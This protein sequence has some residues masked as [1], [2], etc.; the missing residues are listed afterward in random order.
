MLSALAATKLLRRFCTGVTGLVFN[1][2]PAPLAYS[3]QA[4][5]GG[6][7]LE[8]IRSRI[9]GTHIGNGLRSG[10]KLLR[11]KLVGEQIAAYYPEPIYKKDPLFVNLDVERR[12]I[13]LE[14]LRRRG[15]APPKKG[16]G[17]RA[18]RK[19]KK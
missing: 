13:K 9:F 10:R 8:Q 6:E 1:R 4:A 19:K 5:A 11:K 17:K 12:K 3:T 14:K 18:G 15:K 2:S 16:Q 7:S